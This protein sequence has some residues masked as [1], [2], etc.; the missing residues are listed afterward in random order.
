VSAE[1]NTFRAENKRVVRIPPIRR[2]RPIVVQPQTIRIPF[3]VED[4]RVAIGDNIVNASVNTPWYHGETLLSLLETIPVHKQESELNPR[5]PVQYVI[6]S[7][8]GNAG[9]KGFAGQIS[10][11]FFSVGDNVLAI[12]SN[13]VSIIKAIDEGPLS[14]SRAIT[15]QSV[16]ICLEGDLDIKRGDMIVRINRNYPKYSSVITL[17]VCWLNV[18]PLSIGKKYI[19]R[20]T[21]D[22]TVAV[23]TAIRYKVNINTLD[24]ITGVKNVL[25][26]D[27]AHIT[28]KTFKPLKYDDYRDNR[29]TGSLILVDENT[30]E[31]V[32]AGMIVTD[33]EVYSY[34]I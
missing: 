33:E 20:H 31:T 29:M 14:L 13:R 19:I 5:F 12:P 30:F 4:V 10:G 26:N 1:R 25:M 6:E 21:T 24:N 9:Y 32:G 3:K 8:D 28:I 18:K 34:N 23:V 7:T 15:P 16:T 2:L 22:E 11:G 27:I 17:Q